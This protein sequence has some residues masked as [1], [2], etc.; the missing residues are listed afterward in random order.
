MDARA[1]E[2]HK[3]QSAAN[4]EVSVLIDHAT[5][6]ANNVQVGISSHFVDDPSDSDYVLWSPEVYVKAS[7]INSP[8]H[9][10]FLIDLSGSMSGAGIAAIKKTLPMIVNQ[11]HDDDLITIKTFANDVKEVTGIVQSSKK[12]IVGTFARFISDIAADGGTALNDAILSVTTDNPAQTTILL[13]TDGQENTSKIKK[14]VHE[15]IADY[16]AKFNGQPPRFFPIGLGNSYDHEFLKQCAIATNFGMVDAR[17]QH[18]LDT[19]VGYIINGLANGLHVGIQ[20]SSAKINL[21]ILNYNTANVQEPVRIRKSDINAETM[22]K[23]NIADKEHSI[24]IH[25]LSQQTNDIQ[26]KNDII[27]CYV[28]RQARSIYDNYGLSFTAKLQ[29][30][31]QLQKK[32][33]SHL[34]QPSNQAITDLLLL[35]DKKDMYARVMDLISMPNPRAPHVQALRE[36]KYNWENDPQLKTIKP[37]YS[38]NA[39]YLDE[40]LKQAKAGYLSVMKSQSIARVPN[41]GLQVIDT[42]QTNRF[43]N[44]T[45]SISSRPFTAMLSRPPVIGFT[46]AMTPTITLS[47]DLDFVSLPDNSLII[48]SEFT[49]REAIHLN[50]SSP[51][52]R[53]YVNELLLILSKPDNLFSSLQHKLQLMMSFVKE[54]L[55]NNNVKFNKDDILN[56]DDVIKNGE[57]VCRHHSLFTAFL[58][59]RL[60]QMG[61]DIFSF[62]KVTHYRSATNKLKA[63]SFVVYH[64]T[65]TTGIV[66]HLIDSAQG[67]YLSIRNQQDFAAAVEQ[68]D[69][70][71]CHWFLRNFAKD[72]GFNYP[73]AD[74]Q[75]PIGCLAIERLQEKADKNPALMQKLQEAN[76]ICSITGMIMQNPLKTD[77]G[78]YIEKSPK[79]LDL[80]TTLGNKWEY[81]TDKKMQLW[82][83]LMENDCILPEEEV[84]IDD[85]K[86]E[87]LA[88]AQREEKINDKLQFNKSAKS[89]SLTQVPATTFHH[90]V[91]VIQSYDLS[92]LLNST[93]KDLPVEFQRCLKKYFTDVVQVR[94]EDAISNWATTEPISRVQFLY[95][96]TNLEGYKHLSLLGNDAA[97][98]YHL[99]K[100][101]WKNVK[102]DENKKEFLKDFARG[103]TNTSSFRK[104]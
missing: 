14:S 98:R 9:I 52:M 12:D 50:V 20:V 16:T 62:E 87:T 67:I 27:G 104:H 73:K 45:S 10:Q 13:F 25:Q 40:A 100:E 7:H 51:K 58:L 94:E 37:Y 95:R 90:P 88:M 22:V 68:Y 69:K 55:P 3:G 2:T 32:Y 74:D 30:I 99:D 31:E 8:R 39:S 96:A 82:T 6:N 15:I 71:K 35:I 92:A 5:N 18:R 56:L 102:T 76:L 64:E 41:S 81:A 26:K 65:T 47:R 70:L 78:K 54:K 21:G 38:Q 93:F 28:T 63:H 61:K 60:V 34:D 19:H 29:Q 103:L 23:V 49:G 83:I 66:Y 43:I 42:S 53:D 77:N 91:A 80:L 85:E 46:H 79:M 89:V 24:N 48:K 1:T 4:Q 17:D 59:G 101:K 86:L 11:L 44:S 33:S 97:D 75:R 57:G 72:Y 36:F 84:G